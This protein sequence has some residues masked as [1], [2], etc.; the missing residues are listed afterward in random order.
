M[1]S[2]P[3]MALDADGVML[4]YNLAYARA[5]ERTFGYHPVEVNPAAYW[6]TDRWDVK[7][8]SGDDLV[9]FRSAFDEEFW[10]TVPML[11]GV[12][13][14]CDI[15]H[16]AGYELVC[17]SAIDEQH[18]DYRHA[19]LIGHGLPIDRVIAAGASHHVS[20]QSPKTAA[21]AELKPI[22][23]VDDYLPYFKGVDPKIHK[24]LIARSTVPGHPNQGDD[25]KDIDT[26]HPN[27]LD[28]AK[29]WIK[30]SW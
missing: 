1:M 11:E 15:L 13:E 22:A 28:F 5:W 20:G 4:D 19:N 27:L 16:K 3:I 24:A 30:T 7:Q 25:L 26:Q 10:T 12:F 8:L 6:A 21:L 2:K 9:K 14:A 23:F 18:R 29:W 17:V